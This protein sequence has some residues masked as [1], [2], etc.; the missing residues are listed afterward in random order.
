MNFVGYNYIEVK[1]MSV[2]SGVLLEEKQRNLD[3]QESYVAEI[4]KLPKGSI[5]IKKRGNKEYC[6]LKYRERD[7]VITKYIGVASKCLP[8]LQAQVEKRKYFD[9]LLK[10]L[11]ME[12]KMICKVVKD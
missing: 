11:E 5:R 6:Y 9:E 1:E 8:H 2:L 12:Y 4:K 10:E 3:M 7:K